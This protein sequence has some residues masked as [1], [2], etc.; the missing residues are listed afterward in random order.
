MQFLVLLLL[1]L[2]L[3]PLQLL[4]QELF[5]ERPSVPPL[6]AIVSNQLSSS[7]IVEAIKGLAHLAGHVCIQNCGSRT[8]DR[9][10]CAQVHIESY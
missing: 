8:K 1:L 7:I 6:T 9:K 4:I 2:L 3:P 5:I 10:R